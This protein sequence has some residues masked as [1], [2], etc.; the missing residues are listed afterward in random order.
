MSKINS[1]ELKEWIKDIVIAVIVAVIILQ[2]IKPTFVK[3]TSMTPT[4]QEYNF[5]FLSKQAYRFGEPK[6]GDIIVFHTKLKTQTGD[7]KLLIKRVIGLPGDKIRI[8]DG[9]V[10][11]N[12]KALDEPYTKDGYTNGSVEEQTVP[13]DH[14][15]VMGDNRLNSVDSRDPSVGFVKI[16]DVYGKA[17]FRL[18]PFNEIGTLN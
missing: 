4:L 2:F 7:E 11:I 10:W 12:G 18:Y 14:L 16:S 6:Q 17:V 5:L 1:A 8:E 13:K 15:F 9:K 3:E